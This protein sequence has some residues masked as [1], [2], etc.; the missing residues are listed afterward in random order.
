MKRSI[1]LALAGAA[2]LCAMPA[3]LSAKVMDVVTFA[4]PPAGT[5]GY[6]LTNAY[7]KTLRDKTPIKKIVLQTFGGAAGWPARM[8]TG[9]VNFASHCG[10][11]QIEEAY[12]GEGAFK[13]FGRQKNVRIMNT[14]HGLPF[15]MSVIDPKVQT[16]KDLKGKRIF[17]LMTHRD[18][19]TAII[20]AAKHA[21]LDYKTDMKILSV[22]SP[23]EA[24][25]GLRTG[26]GDAFYYGMIPPLAEI[27]Q[28]KGMHALNMP[29][30]MIAAVKKAEPI[31]G[32]LVVKAGRPPL[33]M[34]KD[35][36]TLEIAC[37][38]A[39]GLKTSPET[40]YEA[41]KAIF[42][43]LNEWNSVHPLAKQWSLKRAT[44]TMSAPYHEG[45]IRYYK[46]K[47]VWSAENEA[48]NKA[49]LAK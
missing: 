47:G 4:V 41:T 16:F 46:E 30:D 12:L 37:G 15:A 32:S 13:T 27:K 40:V 17:V 24:L 10:F 48:A 21:G 18:Q 33:R 45:A 26:R 35:F 29:D 19:A 14:G 11:K 39:A 1:I 28:S 31:W 36:Q 7:A 20:V 22:R 43:N 6:I 34:D 3:S 8:Q 44:A 25:Q 2:A 42:E 5:S 23:R 49:W 38:T 9:E